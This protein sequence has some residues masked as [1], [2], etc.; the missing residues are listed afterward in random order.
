MIL[1]MSQFFSVQKQILPASS[2]VQ[3]GLVSMF[4]G[5]ENAGK[6]V[7][8]TG[9]LTSWVDLISEYP[10]TIVNGAVA[11]DDYLDFST[12]AAYAIPDGQRDNVPT[13]GGP[14]TLEVIFVFPQPGGGG[15]IYAGPYSGTARN[16]V[17]PMRISSGQAQIAF[18]RANSG[19]TWI[20]LGESNPLGVQ[21]LSITNSGNSKPNAILNGTTLTVSNTSNNFASTTNYF[22]NGA[23]SVASVARGVPKYYHAR[24]YNRVLT[25]AEIATNYAIDKARFNLS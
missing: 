17:I 18:S 11:G 10:V 25:S 13:R 19:I 14:Y 9:T 2:Y 8:Q 1:G 23:S 4:D 22:G 6:G 20:D 16:V 15:I 12:N 21:H 7:H 5:V 24:L 3:N